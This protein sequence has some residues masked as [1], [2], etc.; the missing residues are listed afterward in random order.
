MT[1]DVTMPDVAKI[2]DLQGKACALPL[3]RI[4][5]PV[6]ILHNILRH[7]THQRAR[8][9]GISRQDSVALLLPSELA[10]QVKHCI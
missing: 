6:S 10:R 7:S 8:P 1:F 9:A 3:L 4:A 2:S 5:M